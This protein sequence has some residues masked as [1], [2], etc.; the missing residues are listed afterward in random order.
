MRYDTVLF[1]I[2][3]TLL[4]FLRSEREALRDALTELDIPVSDTVLDDYSKI[5]DSL[6]KLL[7]QGKI[8]REV[9]KYHRFELLFEKY[10]INSDAKLLASMYMTKLAEKAYLFDGA[11]ELCRDVKKTAKTYI[12]TN[13]TLSIQESR[14]QKSGL[15][16][17][18][19]GVFVSEKLGYAK[20]DP[21]FFDR[22]VSDIQ[23]FSKENTVIIGD[24]L[25]SDIAGGIAYG[26]D[27][28]WYNPENKTA[29]AELAD[30]ITFIAKSYD[31][32][33]NFICAGD[34]V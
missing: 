8:E 3:G 2:D 18:F 5:N 15:L 23:D 17:Y 22:A 34:N 13:G 7:E 27:T 4:D 33:R 14:L 21:R 12:V 11:I 25:S 6:W 29:P 32:I 16:P 31:E 9:L 19:D 1:D 10:G 26:I 28:V 24:S 30:K 20:P